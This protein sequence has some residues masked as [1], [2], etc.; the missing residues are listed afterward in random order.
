MEENYEIIEENTEEVT[1]EVIE[2][3]TE[4]ITEDNPVDIPESIPEQERDNENELLIE[5]IKQELSKEVEE[6]SNE[7]DDIVDDS[8]SDNFL[9][10]ESI[11]LKLDNI[12]NSIETFT[13][14]MTDYNDNNNLQSDINDIS[15]TN[16]LLLLIFISI[17]FSALVNFARRIF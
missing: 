14:I 1:E 8:N 16:V 3:V 13:T 12:N 6:E 4:E 10:N 9:S 7:T 17:L 2:E 15:L 5:Y 11:E